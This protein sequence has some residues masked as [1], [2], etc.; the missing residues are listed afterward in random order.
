MY[1]VWVDGY[2][3]GVVELTAADVVA[4]LSDTDIIIKKC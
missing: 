4:M 3:V 1:K 2:F